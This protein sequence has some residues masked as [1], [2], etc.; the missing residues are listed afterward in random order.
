[1]AR[2]RNGSSG[3]DRC[4]SFCGKSA[5]MARRLIAGP[6]DVFICDECVDVCRKILSEE[7]RDLST[8]F[9]GDIPTPKEIKAYLDQF[10][11]GQDNA[12]KALAVAVYNHY[13]RIA[14][15]AKEPDDVEIEKSNVLLIGP[16]GTGKT[17]LAKTLAKKL[18]VPF[19]IVDATTLTEAGYVGE[20]VE[21]ILLKLI[22]NAGSNIAAAERGIVYIDEIDKIARKGENVSITRDVS[23]EGVQQALL[24]IIEGTVA[25]VPPQGGRKHP[26][27]EM[28]RINTTDILFIC[29]GAFVGLEKFIERRVVQHPMGF[30]ADA[31]NSGEKNLKELFS[32]LHPDDLIHF[33]MIPEFIGRL[34]ITVNL[35]ELK[36]DDLKRIITEPRNA[37]LKQYQASMAIDDVKLEFT[38]GAINAIADMAIKQKTGARGLRAIVERLMT[39]IMFEIPSMKGSKHVVITQEVVEKFQAPEIHSFQKSA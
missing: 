1:M 13:K 20:D 29:G 28:I 12:K 38:E 26:N 10:I 35:E 36:R 23:G 8:Q 19:A 6:N 34:P 30:G 33:G 25:S 14:N 16:T 9:T 17:L 11:I 27:Q 5:D 31:S 32:A 21:N 24:K 15:P 4:C 22:L 7:D 2:L 18:K 37:I 39:D 3:V